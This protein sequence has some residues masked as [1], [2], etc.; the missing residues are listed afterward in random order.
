MKACTIGVFK[1]YYRG[2]VKLEFKRLITL[3]RNRNIILPSGV[4]LISSI[5]LLKPE[6]L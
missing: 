5:I 2:G 1:H 6:L 3:M 4:A